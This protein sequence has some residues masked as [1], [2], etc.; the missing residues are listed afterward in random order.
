MIFFTEKTIIII[1]KEIHKLANIIFKR[2]SV[3]EPTKGS[4]SD[5]E[6]EIIKEDHQPSISFEEKLQKALLVASNSATHSHKDKVAL[7]SLSNDFKLYEAQ[8]KRTPNLEFLFKALLTIKPTSVESE[9]AFSAGGGF[10]TK[11][12]S[13]LNDK[14]LSAQ[15]GLKNYFNQLKK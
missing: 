3:E 12:R 7:D 4:S 2:L 10:A 9:R 14:T 11:I 6:Q 1:K 8:N 15:I 13:R 5:E